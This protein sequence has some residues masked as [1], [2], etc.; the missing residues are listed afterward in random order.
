MAPILDPANVRSSPPP[1]RGVLRR[2]FVTLLGGVALAWPRAAR[3]QHAER[4]RR[5]GVLMAH[6]ASDSEYQSYLSAFRQEIAER[7]WS[8]GPNDGMQ[9]SGRGAEDR[10]HPIR[11]YRSNN[12]TDNRAVARV[13]LRF[14][15]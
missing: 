5:V 8:E 11:T 6:P 12:P 15:C 14:P 7:G 2:E 3:A 9:R 4:V 10:C 13:T 1:P